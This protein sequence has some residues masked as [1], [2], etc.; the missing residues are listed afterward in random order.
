MKNISIN[1][2]RIVINTFILSTRMLFVL[3]MSLFTTRI[4]LLSLGVD[5]YGT[6]IIVGG[7]VSLFAFIT[8]PLV[9]TTQ[10]F[11]NYEMGQNNPKRVN[12]VFSA[13]FIISIV[14]MFVSLILFETIGYY[15]VLNYLVVPTG[16][17][18]VAVFIFHFSVATFCIYIL[19]SPF[20]AII[21][22]YEDMKTIAVIE[23]G[24]GLAKL[25]I[26]YFILYSSYY[27]VEHYAVL[28]FCLSLLMFLTYVVM[29][30]IKYKNV[31]L[32]KVEKRS[33][34]KELS[35]FMGWNLFDSVSGIFQVFGS[36]ILLNIFYGT[37]I[38][39]AY[40]ISRQMNSAI[41]S[42]SINYMRAANPQ[43]THSFSANE[44]DY[45]I[46][47]VFTSSKFSYYIFWIL[48]LPILIDTDWVLTNWLE[49]VPDYASIFI[50]LMVIDTLLN[51]ISFP[52]TTYIFATGKI[53]IF[54][55]VTGSLTL[56]SIPISFV[57]LQVG[58]K[59]YYVLIVAIVISILCL[60][61][62]LEILNKFNHFSRNSFYYNII[63][64]ILVITI[65]SL[66]IPTL[67]VY[68]LEV[69]WVRFILVCFVSMISGI[70]LTYMIGIN[71]MER[72]FVRNKISLLINNLAKYRDRSV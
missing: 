36:N 21:A 16:K 25:G 33:Y 55:I 4:V 56:F 42:F 27:K 9:A 31:R 57:L 10:R 43:I 69:G 24:Q 5:D 51:S 41:S 72:M 22:A 45:S 54:Q 13:S 3:A 37:T 67:I 68:T 47:L 48:A 50:K 58:C 65:L 62:R 39:A 12:D 34:Y 26:A 61:A 20:Q 8:I 66:I 32:G 70:G 7:I 63:L 52:L 1:P 2:R 11:L 29:Y 15:F 59:P 53:K 28:M 40:G 46:K 35:S 14:I 18:A 19:L 44:H 60:V 30:K 23:V 71:K 49:T 64:R 6:Y 17:L 38:N